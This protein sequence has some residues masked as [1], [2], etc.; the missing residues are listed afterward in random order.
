MRHAIPSMFHRRLALLS[1]VVVGGFFLL[2]I[3]LVWVTGIKG[4]DARERAEA[5]LIRQSWLPTTRGRIL[6]RHG[7]VLA[8]D[9][10]S[11]DI[12]VSYEV[13]SG[14]WARRSAERF[15]RRANRDV[16]GTLDSAG[17]EELVSRYRPAYDARVERM[18]VLVAQG[19]GV[20]LEE[21]E[22]GRARVLRRVE[23]IQA[24]VSRRRAERERA[25][26]IEAGIEIG[27]EEETRIAQIAA[28]PIAEAKQAHPVVRGVSDDVGFRF[29]RL[30]EREQSMFLTSEAGDAAL[31]EKQALMPGLEVIDTTARVYPFDVLRVEVDRATLPL[32]IRADGS[33][34]IE[35]SDVA[36]LILGSVRRG[37]YGADQESGDLGDPGRRR[38]ALEEDPDLRLRSFI[39]GVRRGEAQIDTGRYLDGDRVGHTGLEA[40]LEHELRGLRGVRVE[41]LRSRAIRE[42][43]AIAG[44]DIRL[45]LD[46]HLQ[47][48]VRAVLDPGLGLTRVQGWHHNEKLPIGTELDAGAVVLDVGSGEILAMVSSPT[49]PRDGDWSARGV[50]NDEFDLYMKIHTPYLNRAFGVPYPPGSISKALILCGAAKEGLYTPGEQIEATGHYLPGR[51]DV[52]RSWIYKQNP[53]VTHADQLGRDPDGVDAMMVSSNVFF[54]TLGDRLGTRDVASVY[55]MFGLGERFDLGLGGEWA[56]SIGGLTNGINDGSDLS[57]DEAILLGIGQGPVTWT[58][59]HAAD[60]YAS[61]ARGGMRI[62]P[63]LI[64]REG[65]APAVTKLDLPTWAVRETLEGLRLAANDPRFGTGYDFV[66]DDERDKV[67]NAPGVTVWGKTGTAD[68]SPITIDPDGDGPEP[69]MVLRDGDHSWYLTLVGDEGGSPRYVIAVVVDYGGSGGR[70]SGPIANQVIH[71]L[72]Q[73]GYLNGAPFVSQAGD[74]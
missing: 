4:G 71:A 21:I 25:K 7:R 44:R 1:A 56:G 31:D 59:L 53:G 18:W 62:K 51:T 46:I 12:A 41:N 45:T 72:I 27:A 35:V 40:S 30:A 43:A 15:A 64:S 28:S 42:R 13:V 11:Y 36:G 33:L 52:F 10:P 39:D 20:S 73:E 38:Q 57:R 65:S 9:R 8:Q 14:E 22:T 61:I 54:F 67:F 60:A 32:P 48:R 5:R 74:R 69:R 2:A 66:V 17:R 70:V 49:P 50:S 29:M 6:D 55:R 19:A 24:D 34:Q 68:A 63:T 37:V 47:A 16:W 23:G 3:R 26:L 58:P